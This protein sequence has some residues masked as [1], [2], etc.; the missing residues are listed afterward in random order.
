[1]DPRDIL[2]ITRRDFLATAASGIGGLAFASLLV[3][4]AVVVAVPLLDLLKELT[5]KPID[6][7]I[8]VH[9]RLT[10]RHFGKQSLTNRFPPM[11]QPCG[12][13]KRTLSSRAEPRDLF[14]AMSCLQLCHKRLQ[15]V[16]FPIL[17]V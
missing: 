16:D 10:A 2:N 1:M 15:G 11:K 4:V 13:C 6:L 7:S 12:L 14:A 8:L 3:V 9:L 5:R 17:L